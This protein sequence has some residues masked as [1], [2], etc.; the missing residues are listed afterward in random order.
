MQGVAGQS[1]GDLLQ[2]LPM[3][4]AGVLGRS[5]RSRHK[6]QA[7]PGLS[8]RRLLSTAAGM[9]VQRL[10]REK[11]RAGLCRLLHNRCRWLDDVRAPA[12][13]LQMHCAGHG[14]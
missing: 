7:T 2:H 5:V 13:C 11:P 12:S 4:W 6:T 14:G 9:R 10:P 8:A 3:G 1:A